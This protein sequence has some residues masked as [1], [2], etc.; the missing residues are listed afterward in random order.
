MFSCFYVVVVVLNYY[1]PCAKKKSKDEKE[2][3]I[4]LSDN[5]EIN[6]IYGFLI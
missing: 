1:C 2:K 5:F 6:H 3:E 4:I